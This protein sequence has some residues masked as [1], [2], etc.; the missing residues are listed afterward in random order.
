MKTV[1]KIFISLLG[2]LLI[3]SC[4]SLETIENNGSYICVYKFRDPSYQNYVITVNEAVMPSNHRTSYRKY[5]LLEKGILKL[6]KREIDEPYDFTY[7][8]GG[9]LYLYDEPAFELEELTTEPKIYWLHDGY[10]MFFPY[11]TLSWYNPQL[12]AVLW[13]DLCSVNMDT[14]PVLCEQGELFAETHIVYMG[15]LKKLSG[16][17]PWQITF[18]DI[19]TALNLVIDNNEKD[20]YFDHFVN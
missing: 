15:A 11:E 19:A 18:R 5:N 9:K 16:K 20:K 1:F 13:E 4:D 3:P 12:R 2:F 10:F 14:V 7:R 8:E 17:K 6:P